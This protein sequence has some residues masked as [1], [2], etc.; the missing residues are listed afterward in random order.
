[1]RYKRLY[2]W[3][4]F[5][6]VITTYSYLDLTSEL[7]NF[8]AKFRSYSTVRGTIYKVD[9]SNHGFFN[10]KYNEKVYN[11]KF[12]YTFTG[13]REYSPNQKIFLYLSNIDS[14]YISVSKPE[15]VVEQYQFE[16][17]SSWVPLLFF[18]IPIIVVTQIQRKKEEDE[19]LA[20]NYNN[21]SS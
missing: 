2:F 16:I 6:I 1:M 4:L 12:S 8:Q 21:E 10:V 9:C 5:P 13:C 11:A 17:N 3:L 19:L 18:G 20:S 7:Q 15:N 14:N